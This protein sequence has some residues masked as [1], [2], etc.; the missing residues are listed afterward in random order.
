M[1]K[2]TRVQTKRKKDQADKG[3]K[4]ASGVIIV[5]LVAIIK[6]LFEAFQLGTKVIFGDMAHFDR[7]AVGNPQLIGL[8]VGTVIALVG[9]LVVRKV[10]PNDRYSQ[11]SFAAKEE[12]YSTAAPRLTRAVR[13]PI[14]GVL[15]RPVL[16]L[17]LVLAVL[18]FAGLAI[19]T[20]LA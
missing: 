9:W 11:T 20:F 15:V 16:V 6:P 18:V 8:A 4:S 17:L 14:Q 7:F 1:A 19:I 13:Q 12:G 3:K 5:A 10:R 2:R